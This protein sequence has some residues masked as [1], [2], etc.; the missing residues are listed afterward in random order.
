[1]TEVSKPTDKEAIEAFLL[2]FLLNPPQ[3]APGRWQDLARH[4]EAA[5]HAVHPAVAEVL[6]KAAKL[7]RNS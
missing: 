1:M 7:I 5:A 6:L 4:Y 3:H 2:D